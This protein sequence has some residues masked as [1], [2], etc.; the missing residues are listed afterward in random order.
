MQIKIICAWCGKVL[1][2]K[3]GEAEMSIS[4]GVCPE[5]A[6]TEIKKLQELIEIP[7]NPCGWF[8]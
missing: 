4:H 1:G 8:S 5:C 3:E 2:E 6:Y 7:A